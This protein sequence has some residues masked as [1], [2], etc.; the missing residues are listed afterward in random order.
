MLKVDAQ[1]PVTRKKNEDRW[2]EEQKPVHQLEPERYVS[3]L[4]YPIRQQKS[5][6]NQ[7]FQEFFNLFR[8]LTINIPFAEALEQMSSYTRFMK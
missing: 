7:T 5:Q 8:K 1:K 2:V 3:M 6:I 4:Q